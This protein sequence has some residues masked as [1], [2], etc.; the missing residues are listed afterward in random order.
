M[1]KLRV[2]YGH[3][4]IIALFYLEPIWR[5]M[6]KTTAFSWRCGSQSRSSKIL[7]VDTDSI[8]K[9]DTTERKTVSFRGLLHS[10]LSTV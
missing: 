4:E 6:L 3:G 8:V 2:C 10:Q 7:L 1:T 9:T 5:G